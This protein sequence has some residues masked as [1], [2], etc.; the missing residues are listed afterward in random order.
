MNRYKFKAIYLLITVMFFVGFSFIFYKP[1]QK[2]IKQDLV[3]SK[4]VCD[5]MLKSE[6][7]DPVKKFEGAPA[8]V[9]FSRFPEAKRY[10]T[11]I[12]E[13]AASG[14]NYAGHFTF[15]SW[16]CGTG[17]FQYAIVDSITGDIIAFNDNPTE[18]FV[19]PFSDASHQTF[20]IDN[21]WLVFNAKNPLA[22]RD[23]LSLEDLVDKMGYQAGLERKYYIIKEE[24]DGNIWLDEICSE[25]VLDGLY[26]EIQ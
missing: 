11:V 1:T 5:E 6:K 13:S 2:E 19:Y 23:A 21:R 10:Y 18:F 24:D 14:P 12:T 16:G 22:M 7:L 15:V 3:R 25:N 9:N 26:S 4:S 20:S 17:C 8:Q